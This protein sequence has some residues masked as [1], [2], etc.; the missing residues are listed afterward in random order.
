MWRKGPLFEPC[1][2]CVAV[3]SFFQKKNDFWKKHTPPKGHFKAIFDNFCPSVPMSFF[4]GGGIFV[5]KLFKDLSEPE[6]DPLLSSWTGKSE[7]RGA[8]V[9]KE[10]PC[11]PVCTVPQEK[12][13]SPL[14]TGRPPEK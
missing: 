5:L 7:T 10:G 4:F 3:D 6:G 11:G 1:S 2:S 14:G 12:Q 9:L 13:D 8:L